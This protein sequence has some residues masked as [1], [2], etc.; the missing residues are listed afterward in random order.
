MENTLLNYMNKRFSELGQKQV[1]N[2]KVVGPTITIS[3]EVG[4]GGLAIAKKLADE[5]NKGVFCKQWQVISKEVLNAS[6]H[7]L[8]LSPEKVSRFFSSSDHFTFEEVLSAFN[9]KYYK[10]NRVILKTVKEVIRNFAVDGCSIIVGRAGHIIAADV[11]NA[12][13]VR[14]M[15]PIEWRIDSI[16]HR[17]NLSKTDALKYILETEK[18]REAFRRHFIKD[19]NAIETY[20]L[21]IDVSKFN[22]DKTVSLVK[23][24][25]ELLGIS[26][27]MKQKVP[28][29]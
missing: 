16:S 29:F 12:L 20:D 25:F 11:E 23:S 2:V 6:A 27:K 24:A 1:S 9:D 28:F 26:E 3:R 13:H 14:L 7:E 5:L 17:R 18:E 8:K 19:K 21:S 4:C 10:S 15:A 22:P